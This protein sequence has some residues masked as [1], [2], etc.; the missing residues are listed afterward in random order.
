MGFPAASLQLREARLCLVL[1]N[2]LSRPMW[3]KH[4]EPLMLDE[5]FVVRDHRK[6]T[7]SASTP[8]LGETAQL[9]W[10]HIFSQYH[11]LPTTMMSAIQHPTTTPALNSSP[12]P[13][14]QAHMHAHTGTEWL[15]AVLPGCT[16]TTEP[17]L[18]TKWGKIWRKM[19]YIFTIWCQA[20]A[21]STTASPKEIKGC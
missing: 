11:N 9:P 15:R 18:C 19:L 3:F 14:A 4:N 21:I 13:L 16:S 17:E 2:L 1:K 12:S 10:E 7:A 5:N 6:G 8:S 20:K